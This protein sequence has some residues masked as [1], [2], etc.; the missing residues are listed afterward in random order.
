MGF[1]SFVLLI[2][3][4]LNIIFY[5]YHY[6]LPL[7]VVNKLQPLFAYLSQSGRD[8]QQYQSQA[9]QL[10]RKLT[11]QSPDRCTLEARDMNFQ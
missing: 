5:S 6:C 2:L 3:L 11:A 10:C 7:A 1:C 8:L 4:T 9:K